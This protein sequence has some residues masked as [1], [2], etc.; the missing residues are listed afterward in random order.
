MKIFSE[1]IPSYTLQVTQCTPDI[2]AQQQYAHKEYLIHTQSLLVTILLSPLTR[3]ISRMNIFPTENIKS[4][5]L[6]Q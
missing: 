2:A 3:F 5:L 6:S 1:C 4:S